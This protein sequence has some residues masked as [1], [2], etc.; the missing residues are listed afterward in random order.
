MFGDFPSIADLSLACELANMEGI[1][2]PLKE[3]FPRIHNWLY[4][5]MMSIPGFKMIHDKGVPTVVK[6]I[7]IIQENMDEEKREA[8]EEAKKLKAKM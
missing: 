4:N 6:N 5:N 7:S 3:K 8:E 1:K 2:Y